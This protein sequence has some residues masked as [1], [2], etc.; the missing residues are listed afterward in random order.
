M[1]TPACLSVQVQRP[2]RLCTHTLSPSQVGKRVWDDFAERDKIERE[3]K[4]FPAQ[5]IIGFRIIGMRVG[6]AHQVL[7]AAF[8]YRHL[9]C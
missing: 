6:H 7:G 3:M 2:D 1:Y 8:G 5:K 9:A 4:K